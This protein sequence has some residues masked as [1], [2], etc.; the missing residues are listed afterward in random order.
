[1]TKAEFKKGISR[2]DAHYKA[3][4]DGMPLPQIKQ[5]TDNMKK[6]ARDNGVV[7]IGSDMT[8]D[9]SSLRGL[10]FRY[11]REPYILINNTFSPQD[12]LMT[13]AHELAV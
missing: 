1:M 13:L 5:I 10:F 9:N 11:H 4:V 7:V 3:I 2:I 8:G 12:Q 6:W